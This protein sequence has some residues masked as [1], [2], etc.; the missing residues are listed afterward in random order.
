MN[1]RR[2][3]QAL[4]RT[5]VP[6]WCVAACLAWGDT[7]TVAP[8]DKKF[9]S[10][11]VSTTSEEEKLRA[12]DAL[13]N[14]QSTSLEVRSAL[15][16]ASIQDSS[17]EVRGAARFALVKLQALAPPT[18]SATP[19]V[20]ATVVPD[21][22][23][24]LRDLKLKEMIEEVNDTAPDKEIAQA[25]AVAPKSGKTTIQ[26]AIPQPSDGANDPA[27]SPT[28]VRITTINSPPSGPVQVAGSSNTQTDTTQAPH[29]RKEIEPPVTPA[30]TAPAIASVESTP[31]WHST[32]KPSESAMKVGAEK[33]TLPSI[34]ESEA[35]TNP[36]TVV[37][38]PE[39]PPS[40]PTVRPTVP[41]PVPVPSLTLAPAEPPKVPIN[42]STIETPP[43]E[44]ASVS[45]GTESS[46]SNNPP[47]ATP[48]SAPVV[49]PAA[50]PSIT[51]VSTASALPESDKPT[52]PV[53]VPAPLP[54]PTAAQPVMAENT[55]KV[56]SAA[57]ALPAAVIDQLPA[58]GVD[59]PKAPL[60]PPAL[61]ASDSSSK[62]STA[63]PSIMTPPQTEVA[64]KVEPKGAEA[65][66][67][68]VTAFAGKKIPRTE[69]R[70][71]SAA[72]LGSMTEFPPVRTPSA[73]AASMGQDESKDAPSTAAKLSPTPPTA[74]PNEKP[75]WGVPSPGVA[76]NVGL[77]K[78]EMT[79]AQL[80]KSPLLPIE[81]IPRDEEGRK[82]MAKEMLDKARNFVEAGQI[83]E[84]ESVLYQVR[85]LAV[86]YG[87]FQYS[88][89]SL[90]KDIIKA[91]QKLR[92]QAAAAAEKT[93]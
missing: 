21:E 10:A 43:T 84:A 74:V 72:T 36:A 40:A 12:I 41:N 71:T 39:T 58:V 47:P 8:A 67:D 85:E 80:E 17:A 23:Q 82:K 52:T 24:R 62:S 77:G 38:V 29:P 86:K 65:N 7:P 44:V 45:K 13:V 28:V 56:T 87:R 32:M 20:V 63:T 2:L 22:T 46:N 1:T 15:R 53:A 30:S 4:R 76:T 48:P 42:S 31:V 68:K 70:S 51:G 69:S 61:A 9:L 19:G 60:V 73:L 83:S 11:L 3:H 35:P 88:P 64:A 90:E 79:T 14:R 26:H 49:P 27:P 57:P 16:R 93:T 25:G 66:S 91:R 6:T 92:A 54:V 5:L 55:S 75:A 78:S 34:A 89:E 37:P 33:S 18:Q 59:S 81:S 50:V